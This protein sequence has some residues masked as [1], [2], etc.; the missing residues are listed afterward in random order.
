MPPVKYLSSLHAP[1]HAALRKSVGLHSAHA[2]ACGTPAI[3]TSHRVNFIGS[4]DLKNRTENLQKF[5]ELLSEIL[6]RWPDVE[7][8]TSDALGNLILKDKNRDSN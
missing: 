4:L 5:S 3:I 1:P 7:F 8:M 2:F 6:K